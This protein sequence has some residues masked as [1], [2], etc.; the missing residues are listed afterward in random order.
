MPVQLAL[1]RNRACRGP[2]KLGNAR[3]IG[4]LGG[5]ERQ[6]TCEPFEIVRVLNDVVPEARLIEGA[7]R[8][9]TIER[10]GVDLVTERGGLPCEVLG[11][12]HWSISG[13]AWKWW[14]G[15]MPD[16]TERRSAA[17]SAA[18]R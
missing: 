16:P 11:E 18:V 10:H 14:T 8:E 12:T 2:C 5:R 13:I 4:P 7:I 17:A 15:P 1:Y 9:F 3:G 6:R